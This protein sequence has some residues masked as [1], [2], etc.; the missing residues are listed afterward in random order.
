MYSVT[1][2][3]LNRLNIE[4]EKNLE[5]TYL[6]FDMEDGERLSGDVRN[7]IMEV[8]PDDNK[9]IVHEL[10]VEFKQKIKEELYSELDKQIET[11]KHFSRM[12]N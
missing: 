4:S 3:I 10:L 8:I 9:K 2:H 7:D 11:F 12:R 6:E 1:L 5:I